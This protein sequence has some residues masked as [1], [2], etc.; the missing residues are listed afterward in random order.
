MENKDNKV[1]KKQ[2]VNSRGT[3]LLQKY[4]AMIKGQIKNSRTKRTPTALN[5]EIAVQET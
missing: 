1:P 2:A 5:E 3:N 4:L